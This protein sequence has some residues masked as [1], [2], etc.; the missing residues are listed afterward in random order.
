MYNGAAK[1]SGILVVRLGAM[2]DIIHALPAVASLKSSFP[3]L[4]LTWIIESNWAPLLDGN[5]FVDRVIQ[6]D[7]KSAGT[8]A[9]TRRELHGQHYSMAVDFQG[10]LKSA[11]M[12]R[13]ARAERVFGFCRAE[14]RERAA[15]LLYTHPVSAPSIHAVDRNLDLAASAGAGKI[16]KMFPLPAGEP[17]GDL[18]SQA[19]VLASPFAG[20]KSKQW[21]LEYY[22]E[23][24]RC[25]Q[26]ECGMP[27]VLNGPPAAREALG[28]VPRTLVH[29]SGIPGLIDATRRAVAVIGVDSGP[30]HIAAAL[31]KPGVAMF[32]PTHPERNG[33]Y[34]RTLQVLRSSRAVSTY[35]RGAY[36]RGDEID[37]SMRD[38][39]PDQVIAALTRGA[40]TPACRVH[41]HV[42]TC[43]SGE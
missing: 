35:A 26:R 41:T 40:G 18:P 15:A 16:T 5:P 6:F 12:A 10:L 17:E 30:M 33:P 34:G 19:F 14:V 13:L 39:T 29:I 24:A 8:W 23:A 9:N 3:G 25:L 38:I 43:F 20:W 22:A 28:R 11:A 27:L 37:P 2:G 21:P 7:R 4:P 31:G 42:D 32:G 1:A 36:I